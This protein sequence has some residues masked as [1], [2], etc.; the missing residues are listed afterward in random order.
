MEILEQQLK[1]LSGYFAVQNENLKVG[2]LEQ[3]KYRKKASVVQV[4]RPC[5]LILKEIYILC[6]CYWYEKFK[7]GDVYTGISEE[8]IIKINNINNKK[9]ERCESCFLEGLLLWI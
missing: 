4:H 1:M 6:L 8:A 2:M 9:F 5:I 7:L 3:A